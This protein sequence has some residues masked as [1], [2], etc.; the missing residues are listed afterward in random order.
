M[1]F[2][3]VN[4]LYLFARHANGSTRVGA[5]HVEMAKSGDIF[6]AAHHDGRWRTSQDQAVA[7]GVSF[8]IQ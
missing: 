6:D 3:I 5:I 1:N 4:T 7:A 8:S 2:I